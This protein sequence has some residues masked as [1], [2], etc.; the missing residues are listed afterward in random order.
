[1][2]PGVEGSIVERSAGACS[3]HFQDTRV[4][5][6]VRAPLWRDPLAHAHASRTSQ[7]APQD[8]T[9]LRPTRFPQKQKSSLLL[10]FLK[11]ILSHNYSGGSGMNL[12]IILLFST[13]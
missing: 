4:R 11:G 3:Q 5:P 12:S 13:T 10:I 9:T 7:G 6:G 8:G 1:M 2:R